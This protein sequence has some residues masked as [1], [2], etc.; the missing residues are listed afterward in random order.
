MTTAGVE[1]SKKYI[2]RKPEELSIIAGLNNKIC[3]P[4]NMSQSSS[5]KGLPQSSFQDSAQPT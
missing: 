5:R 1:Y 3:F 2:V 4:K